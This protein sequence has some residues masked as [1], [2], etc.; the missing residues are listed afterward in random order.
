M[1]FENKRDPRKRKKKMFCK[2]EKLIFV[3]VI[4]SLIL[5]L[6]TAKMISKA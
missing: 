4:F 5:F 3:I 1:R 6:C 2:L